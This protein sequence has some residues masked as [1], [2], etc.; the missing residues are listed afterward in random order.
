MLFLICE[1][2]KREGKIMI[3]DLQKASVL[4]RISAGLLDLIL[5]VIVAVGACLLISKIVNYDEKSE[6]LDS[7]YQIYEEKYGFNFSEVTEEMFNEFTQ[8]QKDNYNEAYKELIQDKEFLRTYD[9]I[10]NLTLL[11]ATFGIMIGILV[12]EFVIPLFLKNGQTI[13]KK[14]FGI[15]LMM[16]NGV[17]VRTLPLLIRALLGKFTIETM[18]L[19]YFLVMAFFGNIYLLYL[20]IVVAIILVN[21]VL[22][23]VNRKKGMIHDLISYI[24][25]VDKESQLIFETEEELIKYKERISLEENAKKKTF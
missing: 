6:K 2:S 19:C 12:I 1:K 24:V 21:I 11:I 5:S 25:V 7:F 17:K 16:E 20:L 15:C 23:F 18:I 8:E 22:V 3:Y 13:G 9:L 14:C 4:K 10:V